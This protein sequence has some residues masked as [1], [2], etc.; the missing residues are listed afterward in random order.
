MD[1]PAEVTSYHYA[2]VLLSYVLILSSARSQ[3]KLANMCLVDLLSVQLSTCNKSK[4]L[5]SIFT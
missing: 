4:T 2:T 5:E 1:K 3:R